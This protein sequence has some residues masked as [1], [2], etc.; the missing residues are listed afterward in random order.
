MWGEPI[1]L[2]PDLPMRKRDWAIYAACFLFVAVIAAVN[3]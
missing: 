1:D 3:A 2:F